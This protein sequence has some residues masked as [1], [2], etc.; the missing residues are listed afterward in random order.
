MLIH[1]TIAEVDS[2][3]AKRSSLPTLATLLWTLTRALSSLDSSKAL[4]KSI[5]W[6]FDRLSASF[7]DVISLERA[8]IEEYIGNG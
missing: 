8:E 4:R 2:M 3:G 7:R 1:P 5:S 6:S